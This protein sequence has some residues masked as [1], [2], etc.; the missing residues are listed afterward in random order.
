[1]GGKGERWGE[2]VGS[3]GLVKGETARGGHR[4]ASGQLSAERQ[5]AGQSAKRTARLN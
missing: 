4:A 3:L 2:V 5:K 1:M